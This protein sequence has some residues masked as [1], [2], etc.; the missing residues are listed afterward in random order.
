VAWKSF[1]AA[2]QFAFAKRRHCGASSETR[3]HN[4]ACVVSNGEWVVKE[5]MRAINGWKHPIVR[6]EDDVFEWEQAV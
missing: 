4:D 1:R 5:R 6:R 2:K 3:A